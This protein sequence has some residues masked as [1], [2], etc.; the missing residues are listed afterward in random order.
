MSKAKKHAAIPE[1]AAKS[2]TKKRTAE[3][4]AINA[5]LNDTEGLI[6]PS[7]DPSLTPGSIFDDFGNRSSRRVQNTKRRKLLSENE[8]F[9]MTAAS[10]SGVGTLTPES[11]RPS[12]MMTPFTDPMTDGMTQLSDSELAGSDVDERQ[13][14]LTR[15][16]FLPPRSARPCMKA[17]DQQKKLQKD[18]PVANEVSGSKKRVT[19]TRAAKTKD[20]FDFA[21]NDCFESIEV[22]DHVKPS[23]SKAHR[24]RKSSNDRS[25][26][27]LHCLS[28]KSPN[29]IT[30]DNDGDWM[31]T[32]SPNNTSSPNDD[33][34]MDDTRSISPL[35]DTE[36][37][38]FICDTPRTR[39]KSPK[40]VSIDDDDSGPLDIKPEA[41]FD[42]V[43]LPEDELERLFTDVVD[44]E[45]AA[46]AA[47]EIQRF[48]DGNGIF[49]HFLFF[50]TFRE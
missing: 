50:F 42:N 29:S 25:P 17:E 7:D 37:I 45:A 13:V 33:N 5:M 46:A 19:P 26:P 12:E 9:D 3:D 36:S 49:I 44:D 48:E 1:P 8:E 6:G 28:P 21:G 38:V 41:N 24:K 43:Y 11:D 2:K 16:R 4:L 47:R 39:K 22:I 18:P 23:T 15:R 27:P 31:P 20:Y 10:D 35:S 14:S 30:S 34:A 32:L 40:V